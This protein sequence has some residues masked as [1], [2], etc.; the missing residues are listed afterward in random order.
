[1]G[2]IEVVEILLPVPNAFTKSEE[3]RVTLSFLMAN[4]AQGINYNGVRGGEDSFRVVP[5]D[6]SN[7]FN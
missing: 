4:Y 5:Q 7:K 2:C 1:M 3:G 6:L